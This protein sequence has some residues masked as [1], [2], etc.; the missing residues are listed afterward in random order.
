MIHGRLESCSSSIWFAWPARSNLQR[1]FLVVFESCMTTKE[2]CRKQQKCTIKHTEY[3]IATWQ[4]GTDYPSSTRIKL[5]VLL[6]RRRRS[7]MQA[8]C[9]LLTS[10]D[11]CCCCCVWAPP[12]VC[13]NGVVSPPLCA[14][15]YQQSLL[16]VDQQSHE[17]A[18][19]D[20]W[21]FGVLPDVCLKTLFS[22]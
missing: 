6:G 5:H 7:L 2:I 4:K 1:K 17:M 9:S 8:G 3:N 16:P 11:S 10:G 19:G 18:S 13:L 21:Y 20:L 14:S 15:C 12:K 22:P